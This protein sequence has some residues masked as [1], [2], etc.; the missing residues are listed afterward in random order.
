[1]FREYR[2]AARGD[3]YC[4]GVLAFFVVRIAKSWTGDPREILSLLQFGD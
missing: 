4:Q 1:M 2:P 3:L